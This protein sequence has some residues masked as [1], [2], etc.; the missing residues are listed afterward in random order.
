ML[1]VG[2]APAR[3]EAGGGAFAANDDYCMGQCNDI[4]PPGNNGTATL[5]QILAYDTLGT[6]PAHTDD[7]LGKYSSL[8]DG[9]KGL[10]D[11]SLSS[12]FNDSSFGVPADQVESSIKPGGRTDV[13]IVRDKATGTPHI[14]G[15]TRAGTEYGAGYAAGQD[16]LWM[17]DIFRHIGRGQ[18][19][20]FAGGA[21]G[22]RVLE[23]QFFLQGAYNE[24]EMQDQVDRLAKS[25]PRG[26]QAVQDIKDYLGGVNKYIADAKSGLYF[27][28]EYDATGNANILTGDGIEDFKPT[29]LIAIATVVSALFGSGGGN[30]VQSA[31]VKAAA[32]QKYGPTKGAQVWQSFREQNDPEA[33]NTLHDGQSFP[34]AGSPANPV[35]VAMPDKGSVTAQPVVFNPTGSAVTPATAATAKTS[36]Q[37]LKARTKA[38]TSTRQ[39]TTAKANL[40]KKPDLKKTKGMFKKGV[41]P[42]NLFSEK[43]GMS[44]ALVVGG[45]HSKDGHPVAVFGP[46]T[47]YF[48]PQLLMLQELN[49]PGLKARGAAFAGLNMYVQ[50]GRGQ[51]Y[52][53]SATSAG[54]TMTDTY[55]VTLCNADGSPATKDSVAYLDNG[56][57]TP[58]TRIQRD[59]A[60][61][62]TLADSTAAG[63]YSLVAYRT[64][65]GIV[66]YRA[67]IGGKP[68]AYTTLRSTY[69]HEPDTLLGFQMFND[70]A[71][72]T[73]TAGFQQAASNIGYTFNWFYVDSKHTAYFNSGLNPTRAPNVD[74]NLPIQASSTTQWRNWDPTTNTVAGIPDSAHPQSVDQDY[75]IS[76]NNKIAK[77]YTAGT[78]GNG[79]V[80]R[81]NL[82]DKRVKAMVAS[83][84]PVTRISLTQAMEDAAVT[85]L[86]GEDVLPELLA[87]VESAPITDSKQQAA[88]T[89]LKAWA[90]AGSQRKET[91]A[92]SKTY[93]HGSAIR[94]MDA[95]WPLL[96]KAEFAPGMGEDMYTAMTKA[97]T[98]DE[99]PSTGGEGVTHKGSSFQYGWWSYVDKD[100]RA[101]LGKP[102]AGGLG[103]KY[104][105]GGDLA[106]CRSTLLS[107]L[108]QAAATPA[109]TVYPADDTC[110]A[111]DQWCADSIVQS[112]LGG[113]HD[114]N[115]NW[116][117]RPT[118]QMVEQ[119]PAHRGDNLADVALNKTASATSEESRF[120]ASKLVA[121]N[122][123]DGDPSTRWASYNWADNESLTVDLGSSQKIGRAV[124]NWEDA[125]GKAYSIQ[126]SQDGL[127]W[128]TVWSTTTGAGG[129]DN[130][131]FVPTTG[132]YVRMQGIKRGTSYGYSVYDFSV[133]AQ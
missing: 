53:W 116:Q 76:W 82:L 1:G 8:V 126:V 70:P 125:Y 94:T 75:Y 58:M 17:M 62:P 57:C 133:Y 107:T 65:F 2:A 113:I 91:S 24:P 12:Y 10:S 20:G 9:Y 47:G 72:M 105:G 78:F 6:K 73:G 11:S 130:D 28:G 104:C 25:G 127:N 43:H 63:S 16:R 100:L 96:V 13:T 117:N 131:S 54:Q 61:S 132:R 45:A 74:P 32:E 118:F 26:A 93:A 103:A 83:G 87:V 3:A 40:A 64:K 115:T 51:D 68:T 37:A 95:W 44:N 129:K 67:T 101:V 86:R 114:D 109:S 19:T 5:A 23:Q 21:E 77:D 60:W 102:V 98:I 121:G 14:N 59:D 36:M 49:G 33:V 55:A 29:D 108:T 122:A 69:M 80:Y 50:L 38:P 30:Q 110:D 90:G 112:P 99:S 66:Q 31:L 35:G 128:R 34:Y 119:F 120:L 39:S 85:D 48:A 41:L 124:L 15:T 111:G 97:L 84:K 27:P 79:S 46:Q 123:V 4:L 92:G 22:N 89:A 52:S 88:V 42:A 18:L 81:A 106:Q 56:T 7:Q 71:V